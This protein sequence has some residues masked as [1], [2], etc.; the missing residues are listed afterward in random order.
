MRIK[1]T[2]LM[3]TLALALGA[4]SL[5]QSAFAS[6]VGVAMPNLVVPRW[7]T[8]GQTLKNELEEEGYEVEL[9]FA[10]NK[11]ETQIQELR[12]MM[13]SG[14]EVLVIVPVDGKSLTEVLSEVKAKNIPVISYDRLIMDSD[15]VTYYATF[16][17]YKVG[18]LQGEYIEDQLKLKDSGT[19]PKNIEFFTGSIDDN[20][21]NYIWSGAMEVLKPYLD[22]GKLVCKSDETKKEQVAI[23]RWLTDVAKERMDKLVN[24]YG[25]GPEKTPLDAVLAPNDTVANGITI[26]LVKTAGYRANNIPVITGQDCTKKAAKNIRRGLQSM[27]V[28]KDSRILADHVVSMVKAIFEKTDVPLNDTTTYNNGVKVVP[29]FL[30]APQVVNAQNL[31]EILIDSGYYNLKDIK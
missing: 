5:S 16:D 17:N 7:Q 2:V 6:K 9:V 24:E 25:Y 12:Q 15:A 31:N 14:C 30:C 20:N 4:A 21:V 10:D 27:C 8:D 3:T 26:S 23:H 18:L 28:F 19:S 22:S 11:P 29:A 1:N 13:D